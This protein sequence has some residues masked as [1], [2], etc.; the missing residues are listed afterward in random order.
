MTGC[1]RI[2]TMIYSAL[3]QFEQCS[4]GNTAPGFAESPRIVLPRTGLCQVPAPGRDLSH[5]SECSRSAGCHIAA[6]AVARWDY[7]DRGK[8]WH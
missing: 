1:C 2:A 8:V 7:S 6:I 5:D 3:L 4:I